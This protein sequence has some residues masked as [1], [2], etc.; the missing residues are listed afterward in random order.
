MSLLRRLARDQ[1]GLSLVETLIA[2]MILGITFIS[3][4]TAM[5]AAIMSSQLHRRQART[6]LVLRN[7]AEW[8][9]PSDPSKSD[10][11]KCDT[12]PADAKSAYQSDTAARYPAPAASYKVTVTA[13][14]SSAFPPDLRD[15]VCLLTLEGSTGDGQVTETVDIVKRRRQ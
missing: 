6:H 14:D 2:V 5:T 11:H 13:A 4:L 3:I 10:F 8:I 1:S 12:D 15:K 7:Y 9:K